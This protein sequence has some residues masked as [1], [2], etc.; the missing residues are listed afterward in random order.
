MLMYPIY[1]IYMAIYICLMS[2]PIAHYLYPYPLPLPLPPP[3]QHLCG[4]DQAA[5]NG[6]CPAPLE[7]GA[8]HCPYLMARGKNGWGTAEQTFSVR[9]AAYMSDE[10]KVLSTSPLFYLRGVQMLKVPALL[11]HVAAL[12]W[13]P[14]L[15]SAGDGQEWLVLNYMVPGNPPIQV[16]CYY[17]ATREA[18]DVLYGLRGGPHPPAHTLPAPVSPAA[19]RSPIKKSKG[20]PEVAV[21]DGWKISLQNFWQCDQ[22]YC[23]Q[24]FKLIPNVVCCEPFRYIINLYNI[25][26]F[27]R[28]NF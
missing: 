22:E 19:S 27:A 26:Y 24:R 14:V 25:Y 5:Y 10:V 13:S 23:D 8:L 20:P 9:G 2:P 21:G 11:Q 16:V 3:L 17:T 4:L 18:L 7:M 12:P 6:G 28:L 1:P 15:G